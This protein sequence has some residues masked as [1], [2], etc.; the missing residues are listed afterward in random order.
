[1]AKAVPVRLDVLEKQAALQSAALA[2]HCHPGQIPEGRNE[3]NQHEMKVYS[4]NGEDGLLLHIFDCIGAES[5]TFVEFGFGDGRECNAAN[6]AIHFG[7]R[8]LL[9]D[10]DPDKVAQARAY[11]ARML[12]GEADRVRIVEAAVTRENINAL[13]QEHAPGR[14]ID[15][16]SVDIDGNDY[17]VW[18]ALS[19]VEPRVAVVE[20]NAAYGTERAISVQYDP[21]F[22]RWKKH[23]SGHYMGASLAALAR[24]GERKGMRLVGC[25][26]H[27]VNAFFVRQ[28]L[29][30]DAL[31]ARSPAEAYYPLDDRVLGVV[32]EAHFGKVRHMPFEE[33]G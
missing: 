23:P 30:E 12:G 3:F 8:G 13:L 28:G 16:L 14:E 5:R 11:Y 29:A 15:L 25:N 18:E 10:C 33:L 24:L 19:A 22:Q 26:S 31:P 1:M 9:M 7:W 21:T 2:R 20:Y 6:L 17:W 4:Q 32:T 27:G